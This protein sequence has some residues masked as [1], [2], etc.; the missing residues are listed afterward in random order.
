MKELQI[1]PD[2]DAPVA[3]MFRDMVCK[4]MQ[5]FRSLE[6]L[7]SCDLPS[8]EE[9]FKS[10]VPHFGKPKSESRL[11]SLFAHAG[12]RQSITV[13]DDNNIIF[14]GRQVATVQ[15][16]SA[17]RKPI[18]RHTHERNNFMDIIETYRRWEPKDL[19]T[20]TAYPSGGTLLD[21]FVLLLSG[22]SCMEKYNLAHLPTVQQSRESFLAAIWF[23]GDFEQSK[24]TQYKTYKD[25]I[26]SD[27]RGEVF[28]RT[29]EGYIGTSPTAVESGDRIATLPGLSVAIALRPVGTARDTFQIVGPCFLQGVMFGE[30]LL[31]PLPDGWPCE[32]H[33][34]QKWCFRKEGASVTREGPRLWP[35]PAPWTCRF[36]DF[37]DERGPCS[38]ICEMATDTA[39]EMVERWFYNAH[40]KEKTLED[41]RLDALAFEEGGVSLQ[42]FTII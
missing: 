41:P 30:G 37:D 38:E 3:H 8:L 5:R 39:G 31:G 15:T 42:S 11:F 22:V 7:R 1:D 9:G 18:P 27:R 14:K 16:V 24:H 13:T 19:M 32:M 17:F 28:F 12:S 2:Y 25:E 20:S 4:Y 34:S 23:R 10:F 36:C 35:L 33:L 40:T 29:T 21:A 6:A 26:M